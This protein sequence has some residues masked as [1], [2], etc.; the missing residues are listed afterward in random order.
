MDEGAPSDSD[1]GRNPPI[2]ETMDH[3]QGC[4]SIEQPG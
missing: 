2:H 4:A 3:D 1:R